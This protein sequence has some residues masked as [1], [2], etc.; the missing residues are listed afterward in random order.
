MYVYIYM[1]IYMRVC[2]FSSMPPSLSVLSAARGL[3]LNPI[4]V[5][6]VATWPSGF[7]SRP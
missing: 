1:F 6:R 5:L 7:M 3:T 4:D 2:V